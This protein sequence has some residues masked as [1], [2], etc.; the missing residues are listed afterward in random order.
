MSKCYPEYCVESYSYFGSS[1]YVVGFCCYEF[2]VLFYGYEYPEDCYDG[3]YGHS[4][5]YAVE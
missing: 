5:A 4:E 3:G 2:S 1:Y